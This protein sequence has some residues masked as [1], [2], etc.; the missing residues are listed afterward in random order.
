[1]SASAQP[2]TNPRFRK[3]PE[4]PTPPRDIP[5]RV[6]DGWKHPG[7]RDCGMADSPDRPITPPP[8]EPCPHPLFWGNPGNRGRIC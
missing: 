2:K 5:D 6:K 3:L 1:M 8:L 4:A 7:M